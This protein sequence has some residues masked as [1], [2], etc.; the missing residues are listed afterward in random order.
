MHVVR[1]IGISDTVTLMFHSP[2]LSSPWIGEE[3]QDQVWWVLHFLL[4]N[5]TVQGISTAET[6]TVGTHS[7][8]TMW[9]S[10]AS[11]CSSLYSTLGKQSFL[12]QLCTDR[13][14]R[15]Y[16]YPFLFGGEGVCRLNVKL[17][18]VEF[19]SFSSISFV[20]LSVALIVVSCSSSS[21]WKYS[22]SFPC[23]T[24][25]GIPLQAGIFHAIKSFLGNVC[26]HK[27]A[28]HML[29]SRITSKASWL[30]SA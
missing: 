22:I 19:K 16:C 18:L 23:A 3:T 6:Q 13:K 20:L 11:K 4:L 30:Q 15:T 10:H 2:F 12:L 14:P 1:S 9:W 28:E 21:T 24:E 25:W 5:H 17:G 8:L 29:A 27:M 26:T 7:L